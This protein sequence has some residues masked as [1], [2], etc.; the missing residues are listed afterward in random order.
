[1]IKEEKKRTLSD[2]YYWKNSSMLV[3][4][5][6][7]MYDDVKEHLKEFAKKAEINDDQKII[8]KE[9]FGKDLI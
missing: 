7:F 6:V 2:K 4:K 1:M 5:K 8:A 9:I 3:R